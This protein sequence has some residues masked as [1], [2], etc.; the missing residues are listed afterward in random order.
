MTLL[1]I[2]NKLLKYII[3]IAIH[4]ITPAKMYK[5]AYHYPLY[6]LQINKDK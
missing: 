2:T 3:I 6:L 4:T 1:T 5:A